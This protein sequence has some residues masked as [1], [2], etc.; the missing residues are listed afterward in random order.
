M[1]NVRVVA[2]DT[3]NLWIND[4]REDLLDAIRKWDVLLINDSEARMLT[5]EANLRRAARTIFSMGPNTVVIKR[6]EYGAVLFHE[7]Y[8]FSVRLSP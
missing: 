7:D 8:E 5:G 6:G 1:E 3:M 4:F 2:G